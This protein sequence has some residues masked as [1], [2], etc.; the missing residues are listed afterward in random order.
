MKFGT[1]D[2]HMTLIDNQPR[3][4]QNSTFF[5][6]AASLQLVTIGHISCLEKLEFCLAGGWIS[7]RVT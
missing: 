6:M 4:T 7:I 3:A 1:D 5:K 2:L